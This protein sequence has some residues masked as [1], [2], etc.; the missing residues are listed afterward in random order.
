MVSLPTLTVQVSQKV[1]TVFRRLHV[2]AVA[3]V[4]PSQ[5]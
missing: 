3:D 5:V 2:P 4:C 1:I